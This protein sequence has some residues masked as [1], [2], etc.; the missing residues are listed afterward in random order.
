MKKK[1]IAV[2]VLFLFSL[3]LVG[4]S[5]SKNTELIIGTNLT[6]TNLN[7]LFYK[8][9]GD[10]DIIKC[11]HTKLLSS[12]RNGNTIYT[13]A[14]E[15]TGVTIDDY[16]YYSFGSIT[17]KA[18]D[19][20][21]YT[22]DIS[23][24]EG[25]YCK[26]GEELTYRDVLFSIYTI[27]DSSYA[28][29]GGVLALKDL[30]IVGLSDYQTIVKTNYAIVQN[31]KSTDAQIKAA[32]KIIDDSNISGINV[33]DGVISINMERELSD[34]EKEALNIYIA[35]VH[36]YGTSNSVSFKNNNFGITKGNV[37]QQA[38]TT[39]FVGAGPYYATS[40]KSSSQVILKRNTAYF[41]G[42]PYIDSVTINNITAVK[43]DSDGYYVSGGDCYKQIYEDVMDISMITL[44]DAA[45]DEIK[46]YNFNEKLTGNIISTYVYT[47]D[48]SFAI[49][50]STKRVNA[51]SISLAGFNSHFTL[52]DGIELIK[53][54]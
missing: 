34:T 30:P 15:L 29:N 44:D 54:K 41:K 23:V 46:R 49:V 5:N 14:S 18:N 16:T 26:D 39:S 52:F 42:T 24:R 33:T 31:T 32:Q 51:N 48:E 28:T 35:P 25:V 2:L 20:S 38:K 19:D 36:I 4:C 53:L 9:E 8:S 21:S 27:L 45:K 22:Y 17:S 7:P 37:L 10:E 6:A 43:N 12:D 40:F 47:L 3:V 13:S 50:Y 11:I 1:I